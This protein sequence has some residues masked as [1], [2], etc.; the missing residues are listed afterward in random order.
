MINVYIDTNDNSNTDNKCEAWEYNGFSGDD[1]TSL[2]MYDKVSAA[3][4]QTNKNIDKSSNNKQ[5]HKHNH[6]LTHTIN[7]IDTTQQHFSI[8][9]F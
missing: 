3:S 2:L 7:N 1:G 5:E 4:K 8:R 6:T 9:A